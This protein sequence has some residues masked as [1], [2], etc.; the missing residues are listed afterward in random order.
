MYGNDPEDYV[1]NQACVAA[2][3]APSLVSNILAG[4]C[5]PPGLWTGA[6]Y[7]AVVAANSFPISNGGVPHSVTETGVC[8]ECG[9]TISETQIARFDLRVFLAAQAVGLSPVMFYRMSEDIDW[10]WLNP[11]TQKPYPVYMAFKDLMA[12]MSAV[13]NAPVASYSACQM[14]Q[15]ESY[16]GSWPLATMAF[17]GA[18]SGYKGNSILYYTWQRTWGWSPD[19]EAVKSPAGVTIKVEIPTGTS[20]YNIKDMVTDTAV[21]YALSKGVLSYSVADDPV[22]VWL[23]PTTSS[24]V[25]SPGCV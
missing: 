3:A 15:V 17:V 2:N 1:W 21:S 13:A 19:W 25:T 11:T 20:V 7:G 22:E 10:Q 4:D 6:T 16:S 8:R 5:T 12:D 18:K 24:T 14:P 23:N 9:V